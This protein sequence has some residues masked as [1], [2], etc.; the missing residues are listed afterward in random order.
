MPQEP[1][2][3]SLLLH[4]YELVHVNCIGRNPHSGSH[5][6]N[7]FPLYSPVYP[8]IL[9][10]RLKHSGFSKIICTN[11]AR[12]GSPGNSITPAISPFPASICGVLKILLIFQCLL[13]NC[14]ANLRLTGSL[15]WPDSRRELSSILYSASNISNLVLVLPECTF[16]LIR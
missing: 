11:W 10:T 3:I 1:T 12:K 7:L 6:R 8:S 13:S 9:R 15:G 14:S 4:S 2:L 5:H 16:L